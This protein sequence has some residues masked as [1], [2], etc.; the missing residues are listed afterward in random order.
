MGSDGR[1]TALD[2]EGKE[3]LNGFCAAGACWAEFVGV[4]GEVAFAGR[5]DGAG[6]VG[7]GPGRCAGAG[8]DGVD[9]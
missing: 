5:V 6:L 1:W 4:A 8:V 2:G 3:R 7:E 9:G